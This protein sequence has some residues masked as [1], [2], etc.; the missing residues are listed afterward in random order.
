MSNG[1]A[2]PAEVQL[3]V[4]EKAWASLDAIASREPEGEV[5]KAWIVLAPV[6]DAA[7]VR[8]CEE[9]VARARSRVVP[10]AR[11]V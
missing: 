7:L 10:E 8:L 6:V 5:A 3:L 9:V 1:L 2:I 11:A 4:V